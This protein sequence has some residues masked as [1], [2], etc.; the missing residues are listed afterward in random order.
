MIV[1]VSDEVGEGLIGKNERSSAMRARR[2]CASLC[3]IVCKSS[4]VGGDVA[5]TCDC[6]VDCA[7]GWGCV[8]GEEDVRGEE[9]RE[10]G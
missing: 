5:D 4:V 7:G 10:P 2:A 9:G 8:R 1:S 3:F 6:V